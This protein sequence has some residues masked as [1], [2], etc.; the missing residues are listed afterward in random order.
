MPEI[1][2]PDARGHIRRGPEFDAEV[3]RL[4][5]QRPELSVIEIGKRL[6]VSRNIVVGIVARRGYP[7]RPSP[8]VRRPVAAP[9]ASLASPTAAHAANPKPIPLSELVPLASLEQCD[10]PTERPP[11]LARPFLTHTSPYKPAQGWPVAW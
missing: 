9:P 10:A 4:W 2:I 11:T 6:R 8:I 1:G 5:Q 3:L 7:R